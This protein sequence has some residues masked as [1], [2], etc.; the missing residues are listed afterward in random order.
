MHEDAVWVGTSW[1]MT[2]TLAEARDYARRLAAADLPAEVQVFVLPAATALATVRDT[3]P[4]DT[5]VLLGAQNAHW[6]E[7]GAFTGEVSM[8]M[9]RDAGASLVE[10]G[11]SERRS[12]Y[13]ESDADVA[14][15]VRAALDSGLVPLVCFGEP[16]E[17]RE[18]GDQVPF[19]LGQVRAALSRLAPSEVP[20]VLLAYE[21]VW[22]IGTGG[23]PARREEVDPVLAAVAAETA[24][25]GEGVARPTLLYGGSVDLSNADALLSGPQT[26]GLFVGRAAW[27]PESLL[28][29]V[30]VAAAHA[31]APVP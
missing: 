11:H 10:L 15:K 23:R 18:A 4:D 14:A 5:R 17:V 26:D 2:K 29:L 24:A 22:A 16:G 8:R 25:L 13:G 30:S 7:E 6:A 19:V 9:V 21:P 3:L 1:K 28:A 27:D 31:R 20:G 12:M